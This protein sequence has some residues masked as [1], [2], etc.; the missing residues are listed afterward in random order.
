MDIRDEFQVVENL[1]LSSSDVLCALDASGHLRR[2]SAAGQRVLGYAPDELNGVP[3]STIL[4]PA[5]CA[6]ALAACAAA[7]RQAAPVYFEGRY[8][9]KAGQAAGLAWSAF[10][11]PAIELLLCVGRTT[12]ARPATLP[13]DASASNALLERIADGYIEVDKNWTI[14]YFNVQAERVL[15]IDR[16]QCVGRNYW[17]AFPN[18]VNSRFYYYLHLAV[19]SGQPVHF[20]VLSTRTSRWL[21]VRALP[22]ADGLSIFLSNITDRVTAAKHLEQ[23]ALVAQGTDNGVLITDAQGRIEWVNDGFTKHTG[24]TLADMLGRLPG[25]VLEGPDTDPEARATILAYQQQPEPFS[26]TI[27]HYTKAG[28]KLWILLHVTPIYNQAGELTQFIYIQQNI[29]TQK[30]MEAQQAR[31]TQD[32]YEHNRD[33]QQFTYM[34][35]HNL[36]APLANALGLTRLLPQVGKH[37]AVFDTSLSHLRQSLEQVDSVLHDLNL[38]LSI[39]DQQHQ[40]VPETVRLAKVCAQAMQHWAPA[41]AQCEGHVTLDVA[42]DL[43][44]RGTRAYV[45]SIFDNLLSNALKYRVPER[46]LQIDIRCVEGAH[47]GASIYFAGL[48]S[49]FDQ[50]KAGL[51]VFQLYQRFHGGQQGRGLGLFLVKTHVEA[52]GGTIEVNSQVGVGTRF[53]IHLNQ[54]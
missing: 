13:V 26:V 43:L 5:D 15:Q 16:Q 21:E 32:L 10:R 30:A 45:Y 22:V 36:R 42:A 7:R 9:T 44:V 11:W 38:V 31:L 33:L 50:A 54:H 51:K 47:G 46:P 25:T 37:S 19:D 39:R 20:E 48:G 4:H 23:L 41:L 3:F 35:S 34:L 12:G 29:N 18:A 24:Y 8:L 52:M 53:L 17:E 2:V 6:Q 1:M 49:G 27:L 28:E 40:Q 14:T